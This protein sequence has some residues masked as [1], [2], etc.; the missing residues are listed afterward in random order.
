MTIYKLYVKQLPNGNLYLGRTIKNP[1]EYLGSGTLWK[2]TIK[3]N[4]YKVIDIKTWVLFETNSFEELRELGLYYS[5]LFNIVKNKT[6]L[7]LIE[8]SGEGLTNPTEELRDR[9][10]KAKLGIKRK[11]FTD[12]TK[13]KMRDV[14]LNVPLSKH[15]KEAISAAN[16]SQKERDKRSLAFTGR[17]LSDET[18]KKISDK[19]KE[20]W[21]N[22]DYENRKQ[23]T[24]YKNNLIIK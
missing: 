14:K 13:Q 3:K 17:K 1:F 7:N 15:H 9:L 2:R 21:E 8:E 6:W 10:S 23:K 4:N 22:A 16:K 19:I 20:K 5:K 12:V 11:P 18:R 24:H